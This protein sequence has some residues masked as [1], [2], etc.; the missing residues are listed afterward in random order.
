MRTIVIVT[1][2]AGAVC[3]V[4]WLKRLPDERLAILT[5]W[6]EAVLREETGLG[7]E[8]VRALC[9]G[10]HADDDLM[11]PLSSGS[12]SFDAVVVLPASA[13][14][15]AKVASMDPTMLPAKQVVEMATIMGARAMHIDH[16]TGSLE[17]K[18]RADMITISMDDARLM[19]Y[20]RRDAESLYSRLVYAVHQED[21]RDVMVNGLR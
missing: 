17:P 12:N 6:G 5:K 11:S 7:V 19:P 14:F 8:S 13:G 18:K 16:L 10:V 15:L 1:G 3:G 20:F 21:V 9:D 2:A 4:E